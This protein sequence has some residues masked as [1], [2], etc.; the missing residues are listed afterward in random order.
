MAQK[1]G[2]KVPLK[3][4]KAMRD[5]WDPLYES[6]SYDRGYY[7]RSERAY[8]KAIPA[9]ADWLRS[10]EPSSLVDMGCGSGAFSA[11]LVGELPVLGIDLGVGAGYLL[12][13]ENFRKG[14]LTKPLFDQLGLFEGDV[15]ICLEV[16]EHLP[17]Q[18][19]GDL[20]DNLTCTE[21]RV[22]ALSV[23]VP[24][25]WGRHHYNCRTTPYVQEL[26]EARGY[27]ADEE[28]AAPL[29]T[30]RNLASYYRRNTLVFRRG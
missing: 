10:L 9:F 12:P 19:E 15:V 14:D 13:K 28:L 16:F 22:I 17:A 30:M 11:P 18:H 26:V 29:R 6:L 23:A 2:R 5:H 25:Q 20:L 4:W 7:E 27:V 24:G 1:L 8:V 21:P 3:V